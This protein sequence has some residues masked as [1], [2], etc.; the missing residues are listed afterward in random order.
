MPD[1]TLLQDILILICLAL[2]NAYLFSR[3][4]QSPIV[5]CLA[6]GRYYY[7]W[8]RHGSCSPG[9]CRHPQGLRIS[10]WAPALIRGSVFGAPS[11]IFV[12][13]MYK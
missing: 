5:G 12:T 8:R 4:R 10:A 9:R 6:I 2:A 3:L 11:L 13:L 1:L 7:S